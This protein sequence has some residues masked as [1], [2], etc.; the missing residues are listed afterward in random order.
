M[1]GAGA[2]SQATGREDRAMETVTVTIEVENVRSTPMTFYL[3]PAGQEHPVDPG[4]VFQVVIRG[5]AGG[6]LEVQYGDG[7][8]TI[9]GWAGSVAAVVAEGI[10]LG[11]GDRIFRPGAGERD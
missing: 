1:P 11:S 3:E 5:P 10:E 7:H 4:G 8:M 6:L 9:G 2:E